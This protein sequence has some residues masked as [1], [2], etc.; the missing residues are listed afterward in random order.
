MLRKRNTSKI[1]VV[2]LMFLLWGGV[3]S[4]I[5][6]SG[7]DL[8]FGAVIGGNMN[9][10]LLEGFPYDFYGVGYGFGAGLA[11]KYQLANRL[12]LNSEVNFCYRVV[13]D[14]PK[15]NVGFFHTIDY[16]N[17]E[18]VQIDASDVIDYKTTISEMAILIPVML[19]FTPIQHIPFNIS[20]GMVLGFPF[21]HIY[22]SSYSYT[23]EGELFEFASEERG[24]DYRS[25][26]DFGMAF[27]VG[28]MVTSNLGFDFRSVI[29]LNQVYGRN[30]IAGV[31]YL[32]VS[33]IYFTFGVSYFW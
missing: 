18:W 11:V 9:K 16:E 10:R 14:L 29:N 32:R 30:K 1:M 22:K 17:D 7:G 5:N 19:Q 23:F 13:V 27:G 31:E 8:Q 28:Y 12:S 6:A 4:P 24:S 15:S 21:N 20:T 3:L 33:F 25:L 26:V 2:F